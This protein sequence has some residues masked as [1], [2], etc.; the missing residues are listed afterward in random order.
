MTNPGGRARGSWGMN[1]LPV[2]P[3][4]ESRLETKNTYS[5]NA[6]VCPIFFRQLETPK[7]SNPA[8]LK[9]G[10]S[11]AFQVPHFPLPSMGRTMVDFFAFHVRKFTVRPMDPMGLMIVFL[12]GDA[13]CKRL[14]LLFFF[15]LSCEV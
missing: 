14:F 4:M 9:I 15:P 8:A 11:L 7:T 1:D 10:L 6:F 2:K 3:N 5:W 13:T 12:I